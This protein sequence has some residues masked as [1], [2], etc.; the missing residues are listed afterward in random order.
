MT[1]GR[2]L[3]VHELASRIAE[4]Y[5]PEGLEPWRARIVRLVRGW[6]A[7]PDARLHWVE[8]DEAADDCPVRLPLPGRARAPR[9]LGFDHGLQGGARLSAQVL[10]NPLSQ[11]LGQMDAR[12]EAHDSRVPLRWQRALTPRQSQ[13]AV[14]VA[15]GQTNDQIAAALGIAPRTVVR[16]IQDIFKRLGYG[17]RGE[18]AAECALGRPPTP[19]HQRVPVDPFESLPPLMGVDPDEDDDPTDPDDPPG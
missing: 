9:W 8:G 14:L 11:A 2:P 10:L 12:F 16:L 17:N 15:E 13:V 4:L 1:D 19:V 5:R 6:L 7:R 18:L 3:Q